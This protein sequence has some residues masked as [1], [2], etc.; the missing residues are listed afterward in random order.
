MLLCLSVGFL[1]IKTKSKT[2]KNLKKIMV[3]MKNLLILKTSRMSGR[4]ELLYV[5]LTSALYILDDNN[6]SIKNK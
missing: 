2:Y 1:T 6:N 4:Q 3:Q 5:L